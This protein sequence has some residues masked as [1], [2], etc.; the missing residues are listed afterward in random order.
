MF[1]SG[2]EIVLTGTEAIFPSS[3]SGIILSPDYRNVLV[4][5]GARRDGMY[6]FP[7]GKSEPDK[8]RHLRDALYREVKG[9]TGLSVRAAHFVYLKLP[10]GYH[11][12]FWYVSEWEGE[13]SETD[14]YDEDGFDSGA[15]RWCPVKDVYGARILFKDQHDEAFRVLVREARRYGHPLA[16]AV[17]E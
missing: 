16:A 11:H 5:E 3:V 8:D 6:G 7:G 10:R 1:M 14:S 2:N 4:V 13:V 9:E 17:E 12:S 15:P